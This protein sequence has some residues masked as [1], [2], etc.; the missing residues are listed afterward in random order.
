MR[1]FLKDIRFMIRDGFASRGSG[2]ADYV[3][4]KAKAIREATHVTPFGAA[5]L[6]GFKGERALGEDAK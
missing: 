3:D 5:G 6:G 1:Q 4:P 2:K